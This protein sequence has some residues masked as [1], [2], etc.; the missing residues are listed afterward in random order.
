[1]SSNFI[2]F[3][4][5][6]GVVFIFFGNIL[7]S[8]NTFGYRDIYLFVY[9][10]KI[11]ATSCIRDGILPLW[12]PYVYCGMPFMA[13]LSHQLLYPLSF[14]IYYLP[15]AFGIEFFVCL[16]IFLAG[17]FVYILM[18]DQGL[19]SSSSLFASLSYAFSG[20]F[21]STGNTI[22][23]LSTA[24]WTPL[25]IFLY[26]RALRRESISYAIFS[27]AVAGLQFLS[28][29]PDFLYLDIIILFLLTISWV[30]HKRKLFPLKLFLIFGL[31]GVSLSLFQLLPFCEFTFLSN[32]IGGI[33]FDSASLWSCNIFE[34]SGLFIPL[35]TAIS[36][37]GY[38]FPYVGQK[39]TTSLYPGVM[40]VILGI[41]APFWVKRKF[42]FFWIGIFI[43]SL[44]L[45]AG[46]HLPVYYFFYNYM[47]LFAMLKNPVKALHITS[48]SLSIL[49]GF[50]FNYILSK[51]ITKKFIFF[52]F[53]YIL[54]FFLFN[55]T[56]F[57]FEVV[58][59]L[60]PPSIMI[61]DELVFWKSFVS[62]NCLKVAGIILGY[63]ILIYIIHRYK[64]RR[65]L[66]SSIFI[67]LTIFDLFIFN[68]NLNYTINEDFYKKEPYLVTLFKKDKYTRLLHTP[69]MVVSHV[70]RYEEYVF[71][72]GLLYGNIGMIFG[73]FNAKG[74]GGFLLNDISFIENLPIEFLSKI[75][76][77][78][79]IISY[80][81]NE[82]R[83][84][85]KDNLQILPRTFFI[86]SA[87]IIKDRNKILEYMASSSFD[88]TKEV[89]LEEEV[90]E[91]K[92]EGRK[93]L[94]K[95]KIIDYQPNK[96][97]ITIACNQ[98]GF[99][100]LSD[101][102]YP[103]W[104]AYIDGKRTTIYRA[105]YY[106]RAVQIKKGKHIVEFKY[107]PESFIIGVIG[108]FISIIFIIGFFCLTY[109]KVR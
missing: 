22:L 65:Y 79:Y 7:F 55:Y 72:K 31:V 43:F 4:V 82:G 15:F 91:Q 41:L 5:L 86:P 109:K 100:F 50:G 66:I 80:N 87:K 20:I 51:D 57:L 46:K 62:Y 40:C 37:E 70:G 102:Y 81:Y 56:G 68:G 63:T 58:K 30:I 69:H 48:I 14:I 52:V 75:M 10:S 85:I 45:A 74:Y 1:M 107:L 29:T 13:I 59:N 103:G 88:P 60:Y 16:H 8:N 27:G 12:N 77:I 6:A 39:M 34:L 44:L 106:F 54:F 26:L 9:P 105:N 11:F 83:V 61:I 71:I 84:N 32:R 94:A 108:T 96:V 28:G 2:P 76:G 24:T 42:T 90:R 95:V 33:D 21:L 98:A 64:I 18:K 93:Q 92:A 38:I 78:K 19:D 104:K 67:I 35:A 49:A 25:L 36:Y 73:L 23:T 3:L 17:A 89:I 99:L 47:P 97:T 53:P 101:T